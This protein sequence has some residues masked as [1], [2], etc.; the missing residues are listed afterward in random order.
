[1]N[2]RSRW[3]YLI[4]QLWY[5]TNNVE[6]A[7]KW[8]RKASENSTNPIIAVY[9]KINMTRIEAKNYNQSWELLANNLERITRKEKFKPFADIIYFEMA[10]LA[11]E[12]KAVEKASSWLIS[13]IKKNNTN[14]TQKQLAFEL[15]GDINY[16]ADQYFI[17]K[18][19]S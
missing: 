4:A 12:N 13:A 11:I 16:Q 18:I 8:F 2:A 1:M 15:L 3:H 10:K 5:K 9:A 19:S 14:P 17:S 7:Y 6:Q